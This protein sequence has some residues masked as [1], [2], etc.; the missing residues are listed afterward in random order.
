VCGGSL[1]DW[2]GPSPRTRRH[3]PHRARHEV[4]GRCRVYPQEAPRRHQHQA[5]RVPGQVQTKEVFHQGKEQVSDPVGAVQYTPATVQL[6]LP[7][8]RL[9]DP[10]LPVLRPLSARS[11]DL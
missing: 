10:R 9:L 7:S 5:A 2:T 6:L 11:F 4:R 3:R 1:R 8:W